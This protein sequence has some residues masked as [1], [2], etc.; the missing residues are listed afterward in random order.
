VQSVTQTVLYA[1]SLPYFIGYQKNQK[2]SPVWEND[3][4]GFRLYF[5]GRNTKDIF[6]KR[7]SDHSV[8]HKAFI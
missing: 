4:K 7:I 2:D 5:D 6:G 3:K 1:D 8:S